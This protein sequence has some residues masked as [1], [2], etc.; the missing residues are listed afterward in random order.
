MSRAHPDFHLKDEEPID[1][2]LPIVDAHHHLYERPNLRYLFN[3]FKADLASGHNVVATVFVQ[4]RAMYRDGGPEAMRPVGE[5]E[6]AKGVADACT[7]DPECQTRVCAGIVC[8]ADLMLGESVEEVLREHGRAAGGIGS[9]NLRGLRHIAA[10]DPDQG[11]LNSAY[12]TFP[13]ML[14][15]ARFRAGFS[16]L[17]KYGLRFDAWLYYHQIDRLTALARSFPHI[18]I[19]VDHCGGVLGIR[20][21]AG[22]QAEVFAQWSK[23][24][25]ELATCDNV[26]I[27][28]GGLGMP[29][30]GLPLAE[31]GRGPGSVELCTAWRPWMETCIEI[32]GTQRCM[33]ES[34]YPA[35]RAS[36]TYGT[37]WNAMKRLAAA[38]SATERDDLFWRTAA[39]FYRLETSAQAG[40]SS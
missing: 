2:G 1:S 10:W 14:E 40:R 19:V 24:L 18:P 26:A 38:A 17:A 21:Y 28:L 4:A 8:H 30:S 25:R 35:D 6:F 22:R 27:K 37:G 36:H 32:F 29:I 5:T 9:G 20:G 31:V 33:F 39:R 12:P 7:A 16:M 3:E 34:N 11:M 15:D 23:A 13:D